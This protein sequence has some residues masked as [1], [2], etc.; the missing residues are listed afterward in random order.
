MKDATNNNESRESIPL[1][2]TDNNGQEA[3]EY[4]DEE[5]MEKEECEEKPLE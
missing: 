4:S 1:I 3:E 2:S 5:E